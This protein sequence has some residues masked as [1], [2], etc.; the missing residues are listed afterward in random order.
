MS[1]TSMIIQIVGVL[2]TFYVEGTNI[3]KMV[4]ELRENIFSETF[5]CR[6]MRDFRDKENCLEDVCASGKTLKVKNVSQ[7]LASKRI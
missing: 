6:L 1:A 3:F 2:Q 5:L 7:P 4:L